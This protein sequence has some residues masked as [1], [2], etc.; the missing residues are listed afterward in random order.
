MKN[1]VSGLMRGVKIIFANTKS[2]KQKSHMKYFIDESDDSLKNIVDRRREL[3]KSVEKVTEQM[4]DMNEEVR[5]ALFLKIADLL[6]KK[7]SDV[8]TMLEQV[9]DEL[10]RFKKQ[11]NLKSSLLYKEKLN[12]LLLIDDI[13]LTDINKERNELVEIRNKIKNSETISELYKNKKIF[14]EWIKHER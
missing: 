13:L 9:C 7:D 3:S 5:K 11:Q 12:S 10:V 6:S 14:K 1:P 8:I 4:K 2:S